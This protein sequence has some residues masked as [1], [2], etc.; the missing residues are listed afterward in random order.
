[1]VVVDG[2]APIAQMG[3][4]SV[5]QRKILIIEDE[6]TVRSGL[7]D[8]LLLEGFDVLAAADGF[9]GLELYK[10][11]KPDL[12]ILDVMMPGLDGLEVCKR[13]RDEKRG[14]PVIML[15]A[16][17]NEIDK[18]V[19]LEIGADDYLT[20]PFAIRELFA[21]VK[22]LLRRCEVLNARTREEGVVVK[23]MDRLNFGDVSIDFRSYRAT[24]GSVELSLSAKEFELLR[25]LA[26]FPDEPVSRDKLLDEVW[27][28][29]NYPTTRTVDNFI[30]RLRHK[31]ED[32]PDRPQH[33]ITVHG[34]GYKFIR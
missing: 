10:N 30:A 18:V 31:V 4:M 22:A 12:V 34:V 32:F 28:Y 20:K 15:T 17:C 3:V 25:F 24:K 14:T 2:S 33:I 29:N 27:G 5:D 16:K 8:N 21:R 1:M 26:S 13:I 6:P 11:E 23:Q 7:V 19:G 9:E